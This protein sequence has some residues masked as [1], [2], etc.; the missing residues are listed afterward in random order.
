MDRREDSPCRTTSMANGR[1]EDAHA[2][3]VIPCRPHDQGR[4]SEP[5]LPGAAAPAYTRSGATP[6]AHPPPS[7]GR[8][9]QRPALQHATPPRRH[10]CTMAHHCHGPAG[11]G[12]GRRA[13]AGLPQ[14]L[15][16]QSHQDTEDLAAG[17]KTV[18]LNATTAP[19]EC[20]AALLPKPPR[21]RGRRPGLPAPVSRRARMG[22]D[23]T[24][25][26]P[27]AAPATPHAAEDPA[28]TSTG[29]RPRRPGPP[30]PPP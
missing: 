21:P 7:T 10:P 5:P 24:A 12:Q 28:A 25:S 2:H 23:R 9:A 8:R 1:R 22:P 20:L 27:P 14:A 18:G 29:R 16:I 11:S 3:G 13:P 19:K 4:A 26:G 15:A 30:L 6:R 17:T